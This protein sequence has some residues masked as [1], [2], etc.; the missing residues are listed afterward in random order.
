MEGGEQAGACPPRPPPLEI[1]KKHAVRGNFNL[2][3]MFY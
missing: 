3:L 1:R 2:S